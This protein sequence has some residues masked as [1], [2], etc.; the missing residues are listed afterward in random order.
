[1]V[2]D[3]SIDGLALG[4]SSRPPFEL[5]SLDGPPRNSR[6]DR[7]RSNVDGRADTSDEEAV[8]LDGPASEIGF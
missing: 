2:D 5:D 3:V 6:P 4:S 8:V 7:K 1:M